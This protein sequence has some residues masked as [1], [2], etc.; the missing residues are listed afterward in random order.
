MGSNDLLYYSNLILSII[1]LLFLKYK[2]TVNK[3]EIIETPFGPRIL[4]DWKIVSNTNKTESW[5]WL[6]W[7]LIVKIIFFLGIL[8]WDIV[9][10]VWTIALQIV[11]L[12]FL[13]G[14]VL[15]VVL[16]LIFLPGGFLL[17]LWLLKL[18]A[19]PRIE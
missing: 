14:S 15:W 1:Y 12:G 5:M 11:W 19:N 6:K 10:I 2:M 13:I 16:M 3:E 17:P 7:L 4:K 18:C 8:I 9:V